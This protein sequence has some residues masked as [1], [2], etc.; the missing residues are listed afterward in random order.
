MVGP[1]EHRLGGQDQV[2]SPDKGSPDAV[3]LASLTG[4]LTASFTGT[5]PELVAGK[6]G[7]FTVSTSYPTQEG[8]DPVSFSDGTVSNPGNKFSGSGTIGVEGAIPTGAHSA[9]YGQGSI[10]LGPTGASVSAQ[11]GWKL[12]F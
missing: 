6:G 2:A 7:S 3:V 8:K 5:T 11:I 10:S 9:L 12:N 1:N 4:M